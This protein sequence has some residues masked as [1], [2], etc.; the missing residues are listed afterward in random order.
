MQD[1]TTN[2][3]T[4]IAADE[5]MPILLVEVGLN[6]GTLRY[7]ST[8]GNISFGGNTYSSKPMQISEISTSTEGQLTEIEIAFAN[9][10]SDMSGYN[11]AE[12]FDGKSLKIKKVYYGHLSDA[13]DYIEKFNGFMV[14]PHEITKPWLRVKAYDGKP[15]QR[16]MLQGGYFQRQCN[17]VFGNARC[18]YNGY[19]N[20]SSLKATGTADS[21][22]VS[23]LTDN[24]LTQAANYWAHGR[25]EITISGVIYHRKIKEF[26]ATTDTL[27]FD[28]PLH[29]AVPAGAAYTLYKGCPLTLEACKH[30]YAYGPS[31][32]NSANFKGFIHIGDFL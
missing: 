14:E 29:V 24:A 1:L 8:S 5:S 19:A 25:I 17:N 9:A 22:T 20:L 15:F 11:A 18:N 12:R 6:A 4:Q 32:D 3:E 31:V 28:V 13:S 2:I 7:N 10:L 26:N 30:T 27:T 23:T 21:G 16:R